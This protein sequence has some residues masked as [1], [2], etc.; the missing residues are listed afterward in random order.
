MGHRA[1][2]SGRGGER[3][4]EARQG[5]GAWEKEMSQEMV[6]IHEAHSPH[7]SEAEEEAHRDGKLAERGFGGQG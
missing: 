5:L 3:S 2:K 1:E 7:P 6:E 4:E